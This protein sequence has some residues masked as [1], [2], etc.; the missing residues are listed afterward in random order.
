MYVVIALLLQQ[1]S[2]SAFCVFLGVFC[3]F[4][5]S[6]FTLFYIPCLCFSF[7]FYGRGFLR[8]MFY[9]VSSKYQTSRFIRGFS[10]APV[11]LLN[12]FQS[13]AW[14]LPVRSFFYC[15]V[16]FPEVF[17]LICYMVSTGLYFKVVWS[18][19]DVCPLVK[20]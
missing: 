13:I 20:I 12:W 17:F 3:L 14:F 1:M 8:L 15:I 11:K 19:C 9:S 7:G 18:Y 16:W 2:L 6:R 5:V 10:R 4:L